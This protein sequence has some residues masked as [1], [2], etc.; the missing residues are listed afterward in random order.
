MW[1]D[2]AAAHASRRRCLLDSRLSTNG[3]RKAD[4]HVFTCPAANNSTMNRAPPL[5]G[6]TGEQQHAQFAAPTG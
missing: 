6:M 4:R 2:L 3:S 1:R 5:D